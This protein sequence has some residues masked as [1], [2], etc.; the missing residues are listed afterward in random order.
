VTSTPEAGFVSERGMFD[1]FLNVLEHSG[2]DLKQG[3]IAY[4]SSSGAVY[5]GSSPP[6]FDETTEPVPLGL[7]GESKL[8]AERR[9]ETFGR[10]TSVPVFIGR[11]SNLYGPGQNL[12]KRQGLI[13][14]LC[15]SALLRRPIS[16]FV[17]LDTT[18][19]YLYVDD[20][21]SLLIRS[22]QRLSEL[23]GTGK[24]VQKVLASGRSSTIAGVIGEF[25]QFSGR[26]PLIV[27][28]R[29]TAAALQSRDLRVASTVWRDLDSAAKTPLIAG[30]A[31]TYAD[32]LSRF[33]RPGRAVA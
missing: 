10:A 11:V 30:I 25:K 14:E 17:P 12:L 19:D 16:I 23:H 32:M 28:G 9:L 15:K 27:T 3:S 18:R 4:A 1:Q 29:S 24:L 13:T 8:W 33:Q 6:P 20:C 7:Y 22:S 31:S 26:R 21:A 5:G 2:L